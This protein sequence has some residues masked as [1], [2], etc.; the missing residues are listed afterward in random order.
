MSTAQAVVDHPSRGVLRGTHPNLALALIV[1]GQLMLILDS[2]VVNIALPTIQG[3]LHFTATSLSWVLNAYTLAFGGL[4]LLGGRVGDIFGRRRVFIGGLL[5]FTLSSLLGGFAPT[6]TWLLIARAAQ[7][8]GAAFAGP[9][10]LALIATTFA[11]GP[12]RNRALGFYSAASGAGASLGLILGGLLTA[13]VSW[14]WVLFINVPIGLAVVL[15]V[16]L[17]IQ[18]PGGQPGRLDL[19]GALTATTGLAA[20]V[21]GFIR[22]ASVGWGDSLTLGAFAAAAIALA[23]FL[24]IERRAPQPLMPLRLLANRNRAGAYLNMLFIPA[25]MFGVF[26]FL[27]QFLQDVLGFSPLMAGV[28]F[29]PLTLV[30][31]AT[32]RVVPRLLPRLGPK[33]IMVCGAA[34]IAAAISWLAQLSATSSYAAAIVGPL[35]LLGV[36][37]GCSFLPLSV[38]ILSGVERHDS[39]AAA[40]LLQTMQQVG[41]SLGLAILVTIFGAASRDA[42]M[43]RLAAVTP[44]MQAHHILAHGIGI[45]FAVGVSFTVCAFLVALLAITVRPSQAVSR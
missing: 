26:F 16:P 33:P 41:G 7:G 14:R 3:T 38:T 25:S 12:A 42:D 2:T 4:L 21:Y 27:S 15:L 35:L 20:L 36:G 22:A 44:Q 13:T 29:L 34:L 10:T 18:E 24:G 17:V 40:G 23:L 9:S 11:E 1:T 32:V 28:A 39:G 37:L 30:L 19:A 45:A 5:L 43:H 6:A 8:V 31:F